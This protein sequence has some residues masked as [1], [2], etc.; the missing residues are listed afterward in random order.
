MNFFRRRH[1]KP[2]PPE[3][4]MA[5]SIVNTVLEANKYFVP[6]EDTTR[7]ICGYL[8]QYELGI[9]G[10]MKIEMCQPI[11]LLEENHRR[12]QTPLPASEKEDE[13]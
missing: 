5:E 12:M 6:V 8:Q 4:A 1:P 2:K 11:S 13:K 10:A 7:H 9:R 3:W